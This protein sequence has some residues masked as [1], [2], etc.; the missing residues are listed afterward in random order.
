M[1]VTEFSYLY[2]SIETYKGEYLY[3]DVLIPWI[4]KAT[5]IVSM[6]QVYGQL[7]AMKWYKEEKEKDLWG[8][9]AL[10]RISDLLLL[11]FQVPNGDQVIKEI[12]RIT[13]LELRRPMI[14]L[15]DYEQFFSAL[16]MQCIPPTKY[17]PFFHEIVEVEQTEDPWEPITLV[18]TQWPGFMLH[19]MLFSRAGVKVRGGT[20]AIR[21]DI[22][23]RSTLYF[24]FVRSNRLTS[25]LS[26]G[27]GHNSQ[28]RTPFR[29]DY[30]DNIA[31]YYILAH[32]GGTYCCTSSLRE[33]PEFA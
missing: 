28:W 4:P 29:R 32:E 14:Q 19:H 8:L 22:A 33:K 16:G 31:F 10:S 3:Q 26:H 5:Q 2:H 15:A 9:Y 12:R 17:H 30:E 7:D 18:E 24:A 27:W 23:E 13:G 21:K 6:L 11:S 20:N 25:D 1:E